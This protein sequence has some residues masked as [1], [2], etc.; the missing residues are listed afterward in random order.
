MTGQELLA[1]LEKLF[2]DKLQAKIE[3]RGETTFTILATDL[4][5]VAKFCREDL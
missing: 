5:E 3:F 4:R 2:G 1:S